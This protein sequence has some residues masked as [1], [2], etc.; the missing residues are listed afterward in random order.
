MEGFH[1]SAT[2][3]TQSPTN[4]L[5]ALGSWPPET[6]R[7]AQNTF[8][9]VAVVV[10]ALFGPLSRRRGA[11]EGVVQEDPRGSAVWKVL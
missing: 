10:V 2:P 8:D 4:N 3:R 11:A 6:F 5:G 9:V 7:F 1:F